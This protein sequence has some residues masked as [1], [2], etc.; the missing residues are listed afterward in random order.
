M[1]EMSAKYA[2]L[3][4][5]TE[6]DYRTEDVYVIIDEIAQGCLKQGAHELIPEEYKI[7]AEIK[8]PVFFRVPDRNTAVKFTIQKLARG[9]DT[10]ILTGK[11]HEK[12]LC[13]GKIEFP[14]NEYEAVKKALSERLT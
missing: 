6:E 11:A 3:I 13:R 4:V 12:S 1:G 14:W 8:S 9:G 10:V 7:T 2:D 5:L